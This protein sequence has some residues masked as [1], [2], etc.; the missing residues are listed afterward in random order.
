MRVRDG[1]IPASLCPHGSFDTEAIAVILIWPLA[2]TAARIR[3]QLRIYTLGSFH[4]VGP[5]GPIPVDTWSRKQAVVVLK[6]LVARRGHCVHRE[7]LM[8][9]LWPGQPPHRAWERLKAVVYFLR[10]ELRLAGIGEEIVQTK[11]EAYLLNVD[12]I[13]CDADQFLRYNLAAEEARDRSGREVI[14]LLRAAKHLYRGEF[15]E[16]DPYIEE[17]FDERER[18]RSAYLQVMEALSHLRKVDDK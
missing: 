4:L 13:W 5:K 15:L 7:V 9:H 12:A 10:N 16:E 8:E 1:G 14:D 2:T 11:G 18:L 17:F 3:Q 6:F